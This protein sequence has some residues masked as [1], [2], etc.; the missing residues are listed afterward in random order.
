[1]IRS[2]SMSLPRITQPRPTISSIFGSEYKYSPISSLYLF[3]RGQDIGL[4][5]ARGTVDQ[6]N[7]LRLWLSRYRF[8]GKP[9]WV[10]QISRDIGV[11]LSSK[12]FVTHEIDPEVDE[13]RD[14]VVQDFL[15]SQRVHAVAFVKGVGEASREEPRYNFT[16]SAYFTDGLRAVVY[17]SDEPVPLTEIDFV[18]WD[19]PPP[20]FE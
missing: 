18:D 17:L 9:V 5:R 14:Y 19:Y 11:K 13:A 10:G 7:H 3:G 8:E 4:Q 20:G 15:L 16:K 6:R 2:V 1:M 12:T